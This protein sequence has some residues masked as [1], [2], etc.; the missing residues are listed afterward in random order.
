MRILSAIGARPQFVKAAAMHRAIVA[1]GHEDIIVHSGQHYDEGLSAVFFEELG[2]PAPTL[3]LGIG[4]GPQGA[5]TGLMLAAFE[6]AILDIAP[7]VVLVHGDTNT[8]LAAALAA[9]KLGV[10]LA[11]NEA[12]LRSFNRGMPEE[13][14]RVLTDHCSDLLFCPTDGAVRQ[15]AGEGITQGVHNVGDVMLDAALLFAVRA[16]GQG[17]VLDAYGVVPGDYVLA[18][19]HRPYTVDDTERLA[20]VLDTL[21]KLGRP[22]LLPLHPRT[23]A[24]LAEFGLLDPENVRIL[25]AVGYMDMTALERS[26]YMILTDSGGVQK[27]AYFHGVPCVTLRPETEWTETVAAGWNRVV[28]LDPALIRESVNT[29]WWPEERPALFG[30]GH[31]AERIV[32]ILEEAFRVT[33]SVADR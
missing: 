30:D 33:G 32:G 27:E 10:T 15:L 20:S 21:G 11:H 8:T 3:N 7:D 13:H 19:L 28:D 17:G 25:D 9:V 12:G 18:T 14:N 1:R 6:R 29:R 2:I 22:V 23:R 31:A 4:S 24:R 16:D 5:Q 26:A